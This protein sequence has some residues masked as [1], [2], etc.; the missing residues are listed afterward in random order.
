M[1]AVRGAEISL[2]SLN[3][4]TDQQTA[5]LDRTSGKPPTTDGFSPIF[6]AFNAGYS[7]EDIHDGYENRPFLPFQNPETCRFSK[8]ELA[9]LGPMTDALYRKAKAARLSGQRHPPHFRCGEASRTVPP[10][11]HMVDTC[12]AEFSAQTPYFYSV[13]MTTYCEARDFVRGRKQKTILVLG[14]GPIRIGQGI[15]FDYSSVHCVMDA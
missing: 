15:E 8:Q 7:V 10:S 3:R 11:Y 5:P 9:A 6:E 2:D 12:A 13:P 14:S 1:K 4:R